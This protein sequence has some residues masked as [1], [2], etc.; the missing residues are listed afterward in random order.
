MQIFSNILK[1]F[2]L[3]RRSAIGAD[4]GQRLNKL[5]VKFYESKQTVQWK[6]I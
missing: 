1:T 6:G 5:L 3:S 2:Y 4:I